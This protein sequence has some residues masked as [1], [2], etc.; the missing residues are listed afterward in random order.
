MAT[1][2]AD[3]SVLP[4]ALIYSSANCT[5]QASWVAQTK[6]GKHAVF[7]SSSL[8]GWTN[9]N[10]GLAWLEQV[11]NRETKQKARLG[12]DWRLLIL[13]GHGSHL[14][15]DFI[16]YCEAHKI[17]LAV[18]PPHSTHTLQ[19]LDVVCFKPLSSNY[20]AKLT[21]HLFK[22]QG[23]LAVQKG[24]FFPLF[25][26]AW[27]S[28][29]TTRLVLKAFE[30]TG[31]APMKADVILERFRKQDDNESEARPSTPLPKDW[32]QMN[33][34]VR[35]AVKDTSAETSQKLSQTLHQLQVQNELLHH[36]ISGLRDALTTKKQRKNADKP[37]DL[38]REEEYHGGATFWSPSKF[39]RARERKAEKQHQEEQE[40]LAKLNRKELQAAA[41][42]LKEQEKEERRVARERAKEV[43]D[44]MKAEQVAAREARKAT[45]NTRQAPI[46]AHRGKRKASEASLAKRKPTRAKGGAAARPSSPE[47]APAPPP[48]VSSRGRAITLSRKLK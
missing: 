47:A 44:R 43:R 11:F 17:L 46:V 39:E 5:L 6:A 1:I 40:K 3:R 15:I 26:G 18:F 29:F 21:D 9:N 14:S 10:I 19:P 22:T 38:Q 32:R 33:R 2:G 25:W 20:S 36:E 31:I 42:L 35:A 24:D 16:K 45:Q 23:L 27:E 28:T 4:P 41:K 30:A 12:Q 13:D 37:L 7:V 48:K 34:L 8:T